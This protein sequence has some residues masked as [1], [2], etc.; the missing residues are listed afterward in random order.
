MRIFNEF[1]K[2][3]TL[4]DVNSYSDRYVLKSDTFVVHLN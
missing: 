4:L 2:V 3:R 1:D